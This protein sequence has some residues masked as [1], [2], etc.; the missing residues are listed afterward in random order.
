MLKEKQNEDQL[1]VLL[2]KVTGDSAGKYEIKRDGQEWGGLDYTT[3][4]S[5][6]SF[7]EDLCLKG[8]S[9]SA[10]IS[11]C[12]DNSLSPRHT[13]LK[14]S[15]N[16]HKGLLYDCLRTLKDFQMGVCRTEPFYFTNIRIL[17]NLSLEF[18]RVLLSHHIKE[19]SWL[20]LPFLFDL[21]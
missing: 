1:Y 5:I 19:M 7:V 13:L 12:I 10:K 8:P 9:E 4:S 20:V 16:D 11:I 14:I 6:P 2:R 17:L 18:K 3:F 15:C 21:K